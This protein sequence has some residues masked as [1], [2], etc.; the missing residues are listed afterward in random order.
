MR[1]VLITGAAGSIRDSV[2]R[3]LVND[4]WS[5]IIDEPN[6]EAARAAASHM[7]SLV[8]WRGLE[9]PEQLDPDALLNALTQE[10][11]VEALVHVGSGLKTLGVP[12]RPFLDSK[13]A[14]WRRLIDHNIH[15]MLDMTAAFLRHRIGRGGGG[16]IVSL[17]SASGF[18]GAPQANVWSAVQAG[19]QVFAQNMAGDCAVHGIRINC[20]AH[21]ETDL[22]MTDSCGNPQQPAL[23]LGEAGIE[24]GRAT[25]FLLSHR[26]GHI[27]GSCIDVTGGWALH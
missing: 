1:G 27:T 13:P 22:P 3:S 24:A 5:V 25:A 19:L 9:L 20:V 11:G 16:A 15:D 12:V 23:G 14:D 26:A 6:P 4:G 10:G 17:T 2:A 7:G 21:G 18:R 8:S